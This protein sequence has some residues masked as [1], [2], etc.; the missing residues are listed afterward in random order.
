MNN[1]LEVDVLNKIVAP[2]RHQ[3]GDINEVIPFASNDSKNMLKGNFKPVVGNFTRLVSNEKLEDNQSFSFLTEDKGEYDSSL[4]SQMTNEVDIQQDSDRYV[5]EKLIEEH[6]F[7]ENSNVKIIHPYI[8][9]YQSSSS[10]NKGKLELKVARFLKDILAGS[11]LD[12]FK[13][14]FDKQGDEDLLVSMI[15]SHL[16]ELKTN[17]DSRTY[18][19]LL[20]HI[21]KQFADDFNFLSKNKDFFLEHFQSLLHH[22]YFLYLSQLVFKFEKFEEGDFDR[23]EP[24]FYTLDWE[25]LSKRR[26][27][28]DGLFNFKSFRA[29]SENVFVHLHTQY[30]LSHNWLNGEKKFMSYR[31]IKDSLENGAT[32]RECEEFLEDLNEWLKIY[33]EKMELKSINK[34]NNLEEG[35]KSLFNLLRQGMSKDVC[36]NIGKL[37]EDAA[38]GKFLKAR[39]SLGYTLNITQDFLILLTALSVKNKERIALNSLFEEF[40]KRGIALD[41]YSKEEVVNL[42]DNLNILEKKSDS[43]DAQYVKAIL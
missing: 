21:S 4:I 27:S 16:D 20:P 43:G 11:D 39:G 32:P 9:K 33:S 40:E 37:F 41:R 10:G 24:I 28:F 22:Y 6:L 1:K 14:V 2:Q 5:L 31:E 17:Y 12:S 34:V 26:K 38:H 8:F 18:Q 15:L 23:T 25:S 7:Q 42:L 29:R 35:F 19:N 13:E 36:T 3:K 30:Q